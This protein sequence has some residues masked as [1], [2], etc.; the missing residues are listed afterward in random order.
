MNG[1]GTAESAVNLTPNAVEEIKSLLT[2]SE[3][4]G[5]NLRLFIEQ[6]GCSGMQYGLVFDERRDG[7][8]IS[9]KDGVSVLIDPIS[10]GYLRG[11]VVDF[12]DS[13]TAGGFKITN[14]NA[15]ESCGCGKSFQA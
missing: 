5:K 4:A 6:G 14:P 10:A 7:D 9:E 13:L 11:A 12:S 3:N 2:K 8:L 1:I 15:K